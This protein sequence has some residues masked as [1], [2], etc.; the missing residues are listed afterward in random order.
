[1]EARCKWI[2]KERLCE[3]AWPSPLHLKNVLGALQPQTQEVHWSHQSPFFG[4]LKL[5][6]GRQPE[7]MST[8]SCDVNPLVSLWWW[9]EDRDIQYTWYGTTPWRGWSSFFQFLL[10]LETLGNRSWSGRKQNHNRTKSLQELGHWIMGKHL[11]C[12]STS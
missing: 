1:M 8:S 5:E 12:S 10:H 11:F 3:D 6:D 4:S 2:L 7:E 9:M